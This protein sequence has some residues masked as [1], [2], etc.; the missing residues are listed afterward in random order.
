MTKVYILQL[1]CPLRH[2]IL[3]TAYEADAISE[4]DHAAPM[5]ERLDGKVNGLLASNSMNPRCGIC[6]AE[7]DSWSYEAGETRWKNLAEAR[8]A[9]IKEQEK[10]VAAMMAHRQAKRN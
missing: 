5:I 7:R 3:A 6:G 4:P 10:N 1:L 9:L 8:P 2:C